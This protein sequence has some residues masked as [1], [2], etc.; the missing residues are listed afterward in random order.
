MT[1][2]LCKGFVV[3]LILGALASPVLAE[4]A[5]TIPPVA[6][7]P[8]AQPK[9]PAPPKKKAPAATPSTSLNT[10]SN[11]DADAAARLAEG[12]KKF[13]EQQQ[14]FTDRTPASN[15]VGMGFKF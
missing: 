3:G 5:S 6:D 4:D 11:S 1:A 9:K 13:F 7:A 10:N 12:R 2:R 15:D 8:K 14:G